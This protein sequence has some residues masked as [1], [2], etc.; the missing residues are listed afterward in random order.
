MTVPETADLRAIVKIL[1][2]VVAILSSCVR[3]LPG[4]MTWETLM[5][6]DF[7]RLGW[8]NTAFIAALALMPLI[9]LTLPSAPKAQVEASVVTSIVMTSLAS[10]IID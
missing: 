2:I 4:T 5:D 3:R 7:I 9:S 6:F 10:D 1:R 8:P